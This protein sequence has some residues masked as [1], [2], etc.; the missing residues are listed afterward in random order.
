MKNLNVLCCTVRPIAGYESIRKA[1]DRYRSLFTT[2]GTDQCET[3]ILAVG[4]C[5]P[6]VYLISLHV[7]RSPRPSPAVEAMKYWRWEW[8]G[9]EVNIVTIQVSF[10]PNT[11][12]HI[13]THI[14][15]HT[16]MHTHIHAHAHTHRIYKYNVLLPAGLISTLARRS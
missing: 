12:T 15:T 4:H 14:H 10:P 16:H 13:H 3:G 11:H 1:D 8:P 5:P 7:T 2:P 6:S 9:N